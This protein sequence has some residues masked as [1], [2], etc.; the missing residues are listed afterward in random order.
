[1]MV[2]TVPD[3]LLSQCKNKIITGIILRVTGR[4]KRKCLGV[5]GR[6]KAETLPTPP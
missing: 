5:N 3:K 6:L 2:L 4:V 1:M